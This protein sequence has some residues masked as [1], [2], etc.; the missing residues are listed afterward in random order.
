[1]LSPPFGLLSIAQWLIFF[2]K[3]INLLVTMKAT[4]YLE[5]TMRIDPAN[6]PAAPRSILD[7]REPFLNTI[8]GVVPKALLVRQEDAGA[9]WS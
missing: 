2:I 8:A 5:I 9:A 4:R 6:C 7:Y 1:M 3:L